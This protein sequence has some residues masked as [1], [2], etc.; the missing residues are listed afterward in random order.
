MCTVSET[1]KKSD[2]EPCFPAHEHLG[3]GL[4][5]RVGDVL[6]AQ[7]AGIAATPACSLDPSTAAGPV[8]GTVMRAERVR[9]GAA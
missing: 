8:S 9:S 4:S 2:S 6:V 7:A 5:E 1:S 3:I